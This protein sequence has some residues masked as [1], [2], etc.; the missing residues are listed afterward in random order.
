M[1]TVYNPSK[2]EWD[3]L[4]KRPSADNLQIRSRVQEIIDTVRREGDAALKRFAKEFEG[5]VIDD[6]PVSNAEIQA[7]C[8]EV[9]A[10]LK[11]AVQLAKRNIEKFHKAQ[12]HREDK[13]ETISGVICW[14]KSVPIE[15]IGL[16]IPGGT[17]P[18][19]STVLMLAVPAALA[20]C[21]E[22][23]LCTP[24]DM[25]GKIHPAVLYAA[26]IC[27]V[28]KIFKAGGAQAITAMA[29]GTESIPAVYKIFGPGNQYVTTAKMLVSLDGIA[30]D[31]PAGPSELLVIADENADPEFIAAD[32]LSQAEHGVDSQVI[33]ITNSK[34]TAENSADEISRQM[35]LLPR[36]ETASASLKNS[37]IIVL[38]DLESAFKMSNQYAPEHLILN[39]EKPERYFDRIQNAGSVF[40]GP[41]T[42]ESAGDYASGTN[43]TLPTNGYARSFSGVSVDSFMK[44]ITFQ[45]ISREGLKNI[46]PAIETMAEA[47]GLTAHKNAVSVRL[48]RL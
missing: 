43:H 46:G 5:A 40:A 24:G 42:P 14:R 38:Q 45:Q 44:K 21:E 34:S 19:F 39:I 2:E 25:Q 35:E 20:G 47:E 16:Y 18:L 9:S 36:K 30:I 48:K 37:I 6:L 32:L 26:D 28:S 10:E 29:Y 33:L 17:A 23:V 31:M 15:K 12:L 3:T 7:A 4:L 22:I 11:K 41:L 13:I 27:C 8:K 1:K